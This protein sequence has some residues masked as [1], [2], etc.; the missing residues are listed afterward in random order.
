MAVFMIYTNLLTIGDEIFM[1]LTLILR[2]ISD[3]GT[4]KEFISEIADID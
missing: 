1:Y 4:F 2:T 3:R